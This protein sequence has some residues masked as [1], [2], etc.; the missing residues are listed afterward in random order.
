MD[1]AR[2]NASSW[3]CFFFHRSASGSSWTNPWCWS[4][5][6]TRTSDMIRLRWS[7]RLL[8]KKA[9]LWRR[10]PSNWASSPLSSSTR[11]SCH[12]TCSDLNKKL[13][14][15]DRHLYPMK[16]RFINRKFCCGWNSTIVWVVIRT[17]CSP[18]RSHWRHAGEP[19]H[20]FP[21]DVHYKSNMRTENDRLQSTRSP[22]FSGTVEDVYSVCSQMNNWHI[23]REICVSEKE[24]G[25]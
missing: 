10:Q 1:D 9:P 17:F 12:T 25:N 2:I 14:S 22:F 21:V 4:Q 24:I 6:S 7:R 16:I 5:H 15:E 3:D 19:P 8:T 11:W 13:H 23:L 18:K 20:D